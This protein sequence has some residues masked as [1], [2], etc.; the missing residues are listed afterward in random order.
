MRKL[1]KMDGIDSEIQTN[2]HYGSFI[3]LF[4]YYTAELDVEAGMA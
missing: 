1:I 4:I 3:Y 2:K